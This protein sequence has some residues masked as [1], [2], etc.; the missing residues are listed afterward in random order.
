M[1]EPEKEGVR[2][3]TVYGVRFAVYGTRL[4]IET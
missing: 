1:A 3:F 4:T 2:G